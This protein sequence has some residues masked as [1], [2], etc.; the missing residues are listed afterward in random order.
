MGVVSSN[1]EACTWSRRPNFVRK[2]GFLV[3]ER[4]LRPYRWPRHCW[5]LNPHKQTSVCR[6]IFS[7]GWFRSTIFTNN[8]VPPVVP[9]FSYLLYDIVTLA[10]IIIII[11]ESSRGSFAQPSYDLQAQHRIYLLI[12][13]E[14][15]F[16]HEYAGG[17]RH[18]RLRGGI[19]T[20]L[21]AT[22]PDFSSRCL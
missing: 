15:V 9:L 19:S 14:L 18:M 10:I 17:M 2:G 20:G 4:V 1:P 7:T 8:S 13:Q 21:S 3:V 5:A 6:T 16:E 22:L 12:G 11:I